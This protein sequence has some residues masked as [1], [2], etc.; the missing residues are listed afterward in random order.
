MAI[1]EQQKRY[2][3]AEFLELL[4]DPYYDDKRVELV[5]GIIVEMSKAGGRHG[6]I[7][8]LIGELIGP[9]IRSNKLGRT[10]AAET[11]YILKK[12]NAEDSV[13]GLDFAFV[14][15]SRAPQGLP[16]G[17]VPFAPDF[18]VEVISPGNSAEDLHRKL[19]ELLDSGTQL[20]WFVYADT[21]TV[22]VHT[23]TG[24]KIYQLGDTLDADPII[25]GYQV[26]VADLFA[27]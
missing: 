24:A 15:M 5:E 11:G 27:I 9:Y 12:A 16:V 3:A 7:A 23:A 1:A 25:A 2:T 18:A 21:K 8:Q 19:L 13:R 22:S 17:L 10:T 26:A 4:Q 14:Q 6:E 20:I